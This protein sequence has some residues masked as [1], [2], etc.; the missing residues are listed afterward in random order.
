MTS[1]W[2]L[3][4]GRNHTPTTNDHTTTTNIACTP[5]TRPR[6]QPTR[7]N[8]RSGLFKGE[9]VITSPQRPASRW[10][11]GEGILNLCANNYLGLAEPSRGDQGRPR[12]SRPLGLRHGQRAVHL[13]HAA[14]PQAV[15]SGSYPSSSAWR[16][17]SSTPPASTPTAGCSRRSSGPK[18]RSSPTN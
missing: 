9:R 7:R 3:V 12:G 18:T 16:T 15:R 5:P 17:R 6:R 14:D 11:N 13:R 1:W 4:V 2:W 8:P 10:T